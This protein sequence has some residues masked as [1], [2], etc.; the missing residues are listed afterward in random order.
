MI[1]DDEMRET[2]EMDFDSKIKDFIEKK[3]NQNQALKKILKIMN[4]ELDLEDEE[5][6]MELED[7]EKED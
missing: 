2:D 7:I 3:K 4:P 5:N 1:T 6:A